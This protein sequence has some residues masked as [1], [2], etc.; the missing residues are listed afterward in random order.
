MRLYVVRYEKTI[1]NETHLDCSF[2]TG[3]ETKLPDIPTPS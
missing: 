1:E 2:C 3:F